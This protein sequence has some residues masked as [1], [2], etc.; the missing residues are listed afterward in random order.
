MEYIWHI[1]KPPSLKR[2]LLTVKQPCGIRD[3]AIGS[4]EY[5]HWYICWGQTQGRVIAWTEL[6]EPFYIKMKEVK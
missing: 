1:G 5:D 6:P 4:Y 2:V 3:L